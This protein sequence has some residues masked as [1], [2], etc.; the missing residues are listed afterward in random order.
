MGHND[1]GPGFVKLRVET[2]DFIHTN[3]FEVLYNTTPVTGFQPTLTLRNGST[4]LSASAVLE[5][6][7]A[8]WKLFYASS[9]TLLDATFWN[10]FDPEDG[11][12]WIWTTNIG[13]AG[14]PTVGTYDPTCQVQVTY[15]TF[16]NNLGRVVF[17]GAAI[18]DV[19]LR[20]NSA[21]FSGRLSTLS[22]Y[23]TAGDCAWRARSGGSPYRTLWSSTK[24]NDVL[25]KKFLNM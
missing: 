19:N 5:D 25:R 6:W 24:T 16:F 8:V 1:L 22:G 21:D 11:P 15:K 23:L 18:T 20:T 13:Q 17:P 7:K 2:P 4:G 3:T 14:D 12:V 10:I 9:C